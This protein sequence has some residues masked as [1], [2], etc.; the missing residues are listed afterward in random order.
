[1]LTERIEAENTVELYRWDADNI[2]KRLS[3]S[4]NGV[5]ATVSGRQLPGTVKF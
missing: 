3:E 4:N 1:M 2:D 5:G